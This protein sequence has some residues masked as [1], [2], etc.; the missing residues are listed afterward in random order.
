MT[1]PMFIA[2]SA[3]PHARGM[4]VVLNNAFITGGQMI[5]SVVDGA[6]SYYSWGWR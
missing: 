5:A 6:F 3:P 1:V 2:E 4:L